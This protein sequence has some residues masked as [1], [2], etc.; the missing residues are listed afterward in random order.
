[1]EKLTVNKKVVVLV[2]WFVW[3]LILCTIPQH[4]CTLDIYVYAREVTGM[5]WRC[6]DIVIT[7]FTTLLYMGY[8][9]HMHEVIGVTTNTVTTSTTYLYI[10]IYIYTEIGIQLRVAIIQ[11]LLDPD[12]GQRQL[13]QDHPRLWGLTRT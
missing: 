11:P 2:I 6:D 3:D 1:M 4:Y 12:D 8:N 5:S 10:Y 9:M 7:S 13:P